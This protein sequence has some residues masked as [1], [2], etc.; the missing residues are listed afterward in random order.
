MVGLSERFFLYTIDDGEWH[1]LQDVARDLNWPLETALE[2]AKY[3][4]QGH[5]IHYEEEK[6]DVRI[7]AWLMKFP[8][9]VWG[10]PGKRSAGTVF[11]P[12]EGT[13]TLQ[14][15]VVCN[16]LDIDIE[17]EFSVINEKLEELAISKGHKREAKVKTE[18]G[19]QGYDAD[20]LKRIPLQRQGR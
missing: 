6:G 5:F 11:I 1:S 16:D 7:Q 14:K 2:C 13:V 20:T 19:Q 12:P 4:A 15:T 18:E 9:G 3:L 17:V 8:R 10:E